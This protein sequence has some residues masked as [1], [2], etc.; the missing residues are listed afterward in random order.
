MGHV[1][2]PSKHPTE[3]TYEQLR[4]LLLLNSIRPGRDGYKGVI[5]GFHSVQ[6]G[7]MKSKI[8]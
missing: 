8:F 4:V 5:V 3:D 2:F 6:S 1:S 7:L